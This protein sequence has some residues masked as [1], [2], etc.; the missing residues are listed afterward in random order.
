MAA[1]VVQHTCPVKSISMLLCSPAARPIHHRRL[2]D[3]DERSPPMHLRQTGTGSG[4]LSTSLSR[5]VGPNGKV[6][7]FEFHKERAEIA[8]EEFKSNGA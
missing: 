8:A 5:S 6:M 1:A 4:S 3:P 7:T 2:V